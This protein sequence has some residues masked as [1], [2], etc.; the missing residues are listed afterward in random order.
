MLLIPATVLVACVVT[1]LLASPQV[2]RICVWGTI[3]GAVFAV[4]IVGPPFL[5]VHR[6]RPVTLGHWAI[7]MSA[8]TAGGALFGLLLS[9][10]AVA[11]AGIVWVVRGRSFAHPV[12]AAALTAAI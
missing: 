2:R 9:A 4:W 11:P 7:L 1:A 10:A 6:L 3:W 5:E 8:I 12:L